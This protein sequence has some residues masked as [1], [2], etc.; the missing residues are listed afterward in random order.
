MDFNGAMNYLDDLK[1][2]GF[3]LGLDNIKKLMEVMGRPDKK[4]KF[5]HVAGTNG[6]GSTATYISSV[7]TKAG[8]KTGIYTSPSILRFNERFVIDHEE[9][10]TDRIGEILERIKTASEEHNI[11]ITAFEAETALGVV[12]FAEEGC[13]FAVLEVGMGGRLDATN[14]ID[15]PLVAILTN[16]GIDHI[17]YL[18][19]TIEKI[20]YEKA[21]IIKKGSRVVSYPQEDAVLGVL[22]STAEEN[23]VEVKYLD[24]NLV[25]VTEIDIHGQAFSF[26]NHNDV[27]IRMIGD[28]QPYNASLALMAIDEIIEAGYPISEDDL[29]EGMKTA[30]IKG[31]FQLLSSNPI[32]IVD[33]AHNVQG[34]ESLVNTLKEIYGD[35]KHIFV[36]GTLRDK[37]YIKSIEMTIPLAKIYYTTRPDSDRALS[38]LDLKNEIV[39]KGGE[40]VAMGSTKAALTAAISMAKPEDSIICF[41]SLYQVGEVLEYFKEN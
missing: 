38:S 13:D 17:D 3:I 11:Q 25:D 39:M 34:V 12:Y 21:G 14:F 26:K 5:I 41:G 2:L 29:K 31:R 4:L 16:I 10:D 33:G 24:K 28:Y 20:A 18:G 19:D 1:N 7:L 27:K 6:K 30:L 36:F 32:V 40:A 23:D 22:N 35:K 37:D 15:A 9:I 8:Y